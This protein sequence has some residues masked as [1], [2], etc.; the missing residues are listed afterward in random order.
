M[1]V[2]VWSALQRD[3]DPTGGD[4]LVVAVLINDRHHLRVDLSHLRRGEDRDLCFP[5]PTSVADS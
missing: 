1:I 5:D 3:N 4:V 2:L